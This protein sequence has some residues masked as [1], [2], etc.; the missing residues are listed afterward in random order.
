MSVCACPRVMSVVVQAL[1]CV[2]I[3]VKTTVL[4][5]EWEKRTET[6]DYRNGNEV[7]ALGAEVDMIARAS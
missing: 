2:G 6:L 4:L 7:D 1:N 3:D 5:A